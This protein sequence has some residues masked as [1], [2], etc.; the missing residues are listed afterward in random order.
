MGTLADKQQGHK[1]RLAQF[2]V[3][4]SNIEI[5]CKAPVSIIKLFF[6]MSP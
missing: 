4:A 3:G 1:V 5:S 6:L 2:S